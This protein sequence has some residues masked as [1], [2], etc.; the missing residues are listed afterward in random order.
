MGRHVP[1]IAQTT[2]LQRPYHPFQPLCRISQAALISDAPRLYV[3][4]CMRFLQ[5]YRLAHRQ[6]LS[7]CHEGCHIPRLHKHRSACILVRSGCSSRSASTIK[8]TGAYYSSARAG[9]QQVRQLSPPVSP[10]FLPFF[11]PRSLHR[12]FFSQLHA[13]R[14][15]HNIA[16]MLPEK[17]E[18]AI[19]APSPDTGSDDN[20]EKGD[21][22]DPDLS[23]GFDEKATKALIRKVDLH[24]VPVLVILYLLSFLDRT[25]IGNARLAGLEEDLGMEGLDYNVSLETC[26]PKSTDELIPHARLPSRYC[27]HSTWQSRCRQ[28]S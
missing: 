28:T 7:G 5:R 27:T 24:I 23:T 14:P 11:L 26:A 25:N 17:V 21:I 12:S 22:S 15:H 16:A 2:P 13:L 9:T 6:S 18:K 10:P 3:D 8:G 19:M 4:P 20:I 1:D